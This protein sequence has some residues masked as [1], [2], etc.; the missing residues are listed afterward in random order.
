M[1]SNRLGVTTVAAALLFLPLS[2]LIAG[3]STGA[4]AR[5]M[6]VSPD[7]RAPTRFADLYRQAPIG[8]RQ[9]RPSDVAAPVEV[10]RVDTELQRLD[11]EIDRK[12][13]IC[14]GC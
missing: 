12:L 9:P 14:R 1:M 13:I 2:S 7:N 8:H 5:K 11:V 3:E 4:G 10:T 6:T